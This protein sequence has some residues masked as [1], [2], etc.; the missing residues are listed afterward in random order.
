MTPG[1]LTHPAATPWSF[2]RRREA[3]GGSVA[4]PERHE[5]NGVTYSTMRLAELTGV[6]YQRLN[7][8][9]DYGI[10]GPDNQ[11][12]GSGYRRRFTDE[13]LAVARVLKA[14]GDALPPKALVYDLAAQI[15]ER[16]RGGDRLIRFDGNGI[17]PNGASPVFYMVVDVEACVLLE[18]ANQDNPVG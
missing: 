6:H 11:H 7:Y 5:P 16:V 9:S 13:D 1:A 12:V 8:W 17:V 10:F 2:A 14:V 4:E 15:A 3:A 18:L